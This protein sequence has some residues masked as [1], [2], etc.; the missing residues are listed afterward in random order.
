[1]TFGREAARAQFVRFA[2]SPQA[3]WPGN[4]RDFAA[5][6]E[7]MATLA[8]GAQI[9]AKEVEAELAR[10]Q[11]TWSEGQVSDDEA[12]LRRQ[13]GAEALAGLDRFDRVQLADVL[14]VCAEARSLSDAGRVLFAAS[15]ERRSSHNDADR[16]RKYLRKFGLEWSELT[17][18]SGPS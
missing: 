12:L 6:L 4:F 16:L 5:A 1:M 10:L 2:V 11:A 9:S 7:R 13:L 8:P 14:R 3:R 17:S 15:R 18:T